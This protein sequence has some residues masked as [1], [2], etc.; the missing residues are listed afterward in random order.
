MIGNKWRVKWRDEEKGKERKDK[1]Y[2]ENSPKRRRKENEKDEWCI[3]LKLKVKVKVKV[4]REYSRRKTEIKK[5]GLISKSID[6]EMKGE[7][8]EIKKERINEMNE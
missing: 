2:Q 3:N 8:N 6:K 4:K 1:V 5:K 7:R